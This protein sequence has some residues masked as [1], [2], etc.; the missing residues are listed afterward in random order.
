VTSWGPVSLQSNRWNFSTFPLRDN[1]WLSLPIRLWYTPS[2]KWSE[3]FGNTVVCSWGCQG[4]E[5]LLFFRHYEFNPFS[6]VSE[7]QRCFLKKLCCSYWLWERP[8]GF[9]FFFFSY[10]TNAIYKSFNLASSS[11]NIWDYLTMKN[12]KGKSKKVNSH[13]GRQIV[14]SFNI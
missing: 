14:I 1:S 10:H 9:S 8:L 4:E 12:S 3:S 7:I 6:C 11:V 13:S 2:R 5:S